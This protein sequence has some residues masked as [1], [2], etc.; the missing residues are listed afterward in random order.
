MEEARS[1]ALDIE[2]EKRVQ[3]LQAVAA[4]RICQIAISSCW[5]AW[6]DNYLEFVRQRGLLRGAG[7][8]L[9]K[10]K[11]TACFKHWLHDWEHAEKLRRAR[12]KQMSLEEQGAPRVR[13]G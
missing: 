11:L 9:T 8:R 6:L 7:A 2:R 13:R 10:P 5:N 1:H 4:R 12:L 3:H